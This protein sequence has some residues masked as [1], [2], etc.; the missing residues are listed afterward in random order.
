MRTTRRRLLTTSLCLA[1]PCTARAEAPSLTF[2]GPAGMFQELYDEAVL[3]PFGD[4]HPEVR[5]FYLGL[6]SSTQTL[7]TLRRQKD[8]P[9]VDVVLLDLPT[10]RLATQEG[11]L[12][13]LRPGAIREL[14]E[15]APPAFF[16]GIAGPALYS[17]PLVLLYDPETM[18]PP[19]SW[20][21][22]W[23]TQEN[24]TI[25][26]PAP[27]DPAGI[28]FTLTAARL[29]GSGNDEIAIDGGVNAIA[30]L[31]RRVVSW[32]PRPDVY[33]LIAD[34]GARLGA[35]WNM[36]AQVT[37]DRRP[38]RLAVAFP[39]EGTIARVM[40]VNLVKGARRADAARQLIGHMLSAPGQKA[41]VR[42]MYL[43]PVNAHARYTALSLART[44]N[45]KERAE[46]AMP[47]DW[48][49]AESMRDRITTRWRAIV[50][51]AG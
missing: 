48:L 8:Q 29:F 42:Q 14:T 25:A 16:P 38:G 47:V 39:T 35:G 1:T 10:A 4:T 31:G 15:L 22:L 12:E 11:L 5:L 9:G 7:A 46:H 40:T 49:A 50:P 45:T 17:E 33:N 43:G 37:A 24:R 18:R 27:P 34:R 23:N 28:A 30:E 41:M 13:P 3:T 26:V 6:P 51:G 21:V 20:L 19:A 36:A 32:D 2:A 44:A